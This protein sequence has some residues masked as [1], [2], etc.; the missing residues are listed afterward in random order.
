MIKKKKK[1]ILLA[2]GAGGKEMWEGYQVQNL[3]FDSTFF[4]PAPPVILDMVE[5]EK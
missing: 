3:L 5:H 2:S 4:F 1:K